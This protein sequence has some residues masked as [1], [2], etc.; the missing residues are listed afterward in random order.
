M[1]TSVAQGNN[2]FVPNFDGSNRAKFEFSRNPESFALPRYA[3]MRKVN[4]SVGYYLKGDTQQASRVVALD[5][6]RWEDGTS[7]MPDNEGQAEFEFLDFRTKRYKYD[8]SIGYKAVDQADFDVVPFNM[9][10]KAQQAMTGRTYDAMTALVAGLTTTDTA[11]NYGGGKWSAAAAATPYI[12]RTFMAVQ[13]IIHKATQGAVGPDA[14][15]CVIGPDIAAVM[16]RSAEIT[17]FIKQQPSSPEIMENKAFFYKWGLPKML[18]GVEL[19]VE[20]AVRT[21]NVKGATLSRGYLASNDEAYFVTNTVDV[22]K[23]EELPAGEGIGL[24]DTLTL[25]MYE[26]MTVENRDDPDNRRVLGRVVDDFASEVT[27]AESGVKVT[28]VNL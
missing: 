6:H 5:L 26:E 7:G 12:L 22:K 21:A 9:R 13:Q 11:T 24:Y 1:A 19:I 17:D 10:A 8:F 4:R 16:R 15:K 27:C 20:D 2:T 14:I 28:A 18:Y 25:F 3:A 23:Q